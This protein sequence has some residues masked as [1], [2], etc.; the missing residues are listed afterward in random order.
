MVTKA[1]RILITTET[2]E[3]IVVRQDQDRSVILGLCKECMAEVEL[4]DFNSAMSEFG[5]R[6]RE[7]VAGLGSGRFHSM[8]TDRG[9]LH[10]CKPS[11]QTRRL[12]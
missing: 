12:P 2:H 4:I 6:G 7:L 9:H 5:F 1:K 10:I 3:K 8:E 11:L